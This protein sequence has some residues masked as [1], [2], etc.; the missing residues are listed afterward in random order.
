MELRSP[1]R[2]SQ[3]THVRDASVHD[4]ARYLTELLDLH[5]IGVDYLSTDI[6]HEVSGPRRLACSNQ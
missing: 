6:R 5:N 1:L 2:T 3:H 4:V